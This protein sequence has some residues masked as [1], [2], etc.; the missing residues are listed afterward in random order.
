MSNEGWLNK[1]FGERLKA[2]REARGWSQPQFAELLLAQ[3]VTPMHATTIA[4]IEAGKRS[5]RIVEAVGMAD[6]FEVPLDT[7]MGRSVGPADA[8]FQVALRVLRDSAKRSAD[9]SLDI[10]RD[11]GQQVRHVSTSFEFDASIELQK[12][13]EAACRSLDGAYDAVEELAQYTDDVLR[14]KASAERKQPRKAKVGR[15]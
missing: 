12:L 8:A 13:A 6:V 10:A 1:R 9:Q 7:L 11:I 14:Q 2:E 3:G 5:V 15:L 4:K